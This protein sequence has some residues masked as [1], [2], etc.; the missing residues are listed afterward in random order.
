[1]S[2]SALAM[3]CAAAALIVLFVLTSP[4]PGGSQSPSAQP[5]APVASAEDVQAL[6]ER[7]GAFWAA[8]LAGDPKVQW[9]LLEPRGRAR[10]TIQ[11]YGSDRGALRYIAYQV[12]DATVNGYFAVVKVRVMVQPILP[13]GRRVG[14]QTTL[15]EDYWVKIRGIWYR[16][17]EEGQPG[18]AQEGAS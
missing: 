1:M 10:L 8:R 2:V 14:V 3:R 16:K 11:E 9:E 15:A 5:P 6:R 12:E 17:L 13:S 7:V 4:I 18:Q